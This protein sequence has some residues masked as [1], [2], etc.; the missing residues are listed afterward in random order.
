MP[1]KNY[2]K[3]YKKKYNKKS[4]TYIPKKYQAKKQSEKSI[5]TIVNKVLRKKIEVKHID[6]AY[7]FRA[8]YHN[9]YTL[10]G[11]F[12][13]NLV[14]GSGVII[15]QGALE[16]QMIGTEVNIIGTMFKIMFLI[17]PDRMNTKFRVLIIRHPTG[18]DPTSSY[19]QVFDNLTGNLLI[20]NVDRH[21]VTVL[22]DKILGYKDIVPTN[23]TD[24]ITFFRTII[25]PKQKYKMHYIDDGNSISNTPK[26]RDTLIIMTYDT[27][28]SLITDNISACQVNQRTYF[29]DI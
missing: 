11:S 18:Y 9:N 24:Q 29:T 13:T 21:R 2:K 20:D 26:F 12:T 14:G 7:D 1:P 17:A 27:F 4:K 22:Y 16:N 5:T 25:V 10:A 3:N 28:G 15:N 6:K 19:T 8:L 23:S